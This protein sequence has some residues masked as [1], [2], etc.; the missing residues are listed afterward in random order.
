MD[1]KT[2][3]VRV[4]RAGRAVHVGQVSESNE[5]LARCAALSQYG[6]SEEELAEEGGCRRCSA[7]YS[8][9]DFDVSPAQ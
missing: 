1:M 8:D 2:W 5:S 6:V 7:I 3:N 9:E 4:V